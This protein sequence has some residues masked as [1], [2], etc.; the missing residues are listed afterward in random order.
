[1][2]FQDIGRRRVKA[3]RP[4][5]P[6]SPARRP[7]LSSSRSKSI[8]DEV[9]ADTS[10]EESITVEIECQAE[11][12]RRTSRPTTEYAKIHEEIVQ[13]Q[14]LVRELEVF[15]ETSGLSPEN[16]WR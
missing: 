8:I 9:A 11:S 4:R 7:R 3:D 6:P 5:Q 2:S 16:Q 10:M 1:M 14:R 15:E 12:V 13:F